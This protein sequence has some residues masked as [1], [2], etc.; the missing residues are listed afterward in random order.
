MWN[1][2]GIALIF[3]VLGLVAGLFAGNYICKT[4]GWTS[5]F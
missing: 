5:G 2:L 4:G 3:V 1:K